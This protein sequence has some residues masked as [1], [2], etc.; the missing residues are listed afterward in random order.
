[1]IQKYFLFII[2]FATIVQA[3]QAQPAYNGSTGLLETPN[4]P[5]WY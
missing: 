1:M 5:M 2:L 4:A 3:N